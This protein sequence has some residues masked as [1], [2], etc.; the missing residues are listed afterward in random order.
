[1][2]TALSTLDNGLISRSM[3]MERLFTKLVLFMKGAGKMI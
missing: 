3:E 1:M 2:K